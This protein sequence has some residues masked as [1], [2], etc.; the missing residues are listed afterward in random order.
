[1]ISFSAKDLCTRS[2]MQIM[3]F[4][5]FPEKR[6]KPS[7]N[8]LYGETFQHKVAQQTRDVIGEEMRGTFICDDICINFSNDIVTKN[9]II[10]VKSI[11]RKVEDWYFKSSILQCAVYSALLKKAEGKL[12]TATFFAEMGNPIVETNVNTDINYFLNFGGALF[13]VKVD[14]ADKIVDFIVNKAKHCTSWEQAKEFDEKYKQK[15]Y[16][17]LKH[18]FHYN[19][20]KEIDICDSFKILSK[21]SD[22]ARQMMEQNS[23]RI[24][25]L[26]GRNGIYTNELSFHPNGKCGCIETNGKYMFGICCNHLMWAEGYVEGGEA[27]MKGIENNNVILVYGNHKGELESELL[28]FSEKEG[29]SSYVIP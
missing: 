16:E 13:E 4:N 18:Y 22:I 25:C 9:S 29:V 11:D 7:T 19:K 15:E 26:R 23:S 1:M 27:F 21:H 24:I 3:F 6:P 20:I 17:I 8:M 14:D 12:V 5:E 10:E 2:C 28:T